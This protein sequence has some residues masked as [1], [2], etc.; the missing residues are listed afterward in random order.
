MGPACR[1][2]PARPSGAVGR[3]VG[4]H[5]PAAQMATAE[6]GQRRTG[7]PGDGG[8]GGI[9]ALEPETHATR[10]AGSRPPGRCRY[11]HRARQHPS[12][13][14]AP[15]AHRC[16]TAIPVAPGSRARCRG[17][18]GTA[19]APHAPGRGPLRHRRYPGYAAGPQ[20]PAA[21]PR[22]A[23]Q[24]HPLCVVQPG[25]ARGFGGV[26]RQPA[27]HRA[28]RGSAGA[29]RT[30]PEQPALEAG[31]ADRA[32][33]G[34]PAQ[35]QRL[36]FHR[37]IDPVCPN[38][39]HPRHAGNPCDG[40]GAL[41][42]L[43]ARCVACAPANRCAGRGTPPGFRADRYATG[44]PV[45]PASV[46]PAAAGRSGPAQRWPGC[47][48]R[49]MA[50]LVFSGAPERAGDRCATAGPAAGAGTGGTASPHPARTAQCGRAVESGADSARLCRQA[51]PTRRA[52]PSRC[53]AAALAAHAGPAGGIWRSGAVGRRQR[54]HTR[55]HPQHTATAQ[56]AIAGHR[57]AV[58]ARSGLRL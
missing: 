42:A 17:A 46:E 54:A 25:P 5:A 56:C 48:S 28:P 7:P 49:R 8:T 41:P 22:G 20:C 51:S 38:P 3:A 23:R 33:A 10:A 57:G 24:P 13:Q 19:I 29:G 12:I 32:P 30:V 35:W 1:L 26:H 4:R 53:A 6:T 44:T 31:G 21:Q 39:R 37:G 27:Q 47:R 18:G 36:R 45:W 11:R 9:P 15:P 2:G 50:T 52:R 14:S 40:R 58:A 55:R 43:L 16:R 34:F